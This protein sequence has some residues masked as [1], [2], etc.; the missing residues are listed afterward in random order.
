MNDYR[1]SCGLA[2]G[3]AGELTDHL[4]E[5]FTPDNDQGHDGMTHV[6]LTPNLACSCGFAAAN[7]AELD[8][9]FLTAFTPP[10][11]TGRDGARHGRQAR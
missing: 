1:C 8:N 4:L 6:E 5:V 9:H 7:P 2:A 10:G 11:A 3:S